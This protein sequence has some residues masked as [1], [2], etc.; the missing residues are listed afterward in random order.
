MKKTSFL[1]GIILCLFTGTAHAAGTCTGTFFNPVTDVCWTCIFPIKI[2]GVT[3]ASFGQEDTDTIDVTPICFCPDRPFPLNLVPGIP[4]SFWEPFRV[5]EVVREPGCFPT[6]GGLKLFST[7]TGSGTVGTTSPAS[8]KH[9]FYHVHYMIY[10]VFYVMELLIDFTCVESSGFDVAYVSEFDPLWMNSELSNFLNP[11]AVLFANV[12][13]QTA[14]IADCTTATAGFPLDPLFWCAGCWGSM[15]P[16]TGHDASSISP[17]QA[18][19]LLATR[20]LAKMHREGLAWG[21]VG[22]PGLC[23]QYPMPV[24]Q[25][26]MYK[27]SMIYPRSQTNGSCCQPIG[28]S[29]MIWGINRTY[30]YAGED[31]GYL[32][33][34]K[35]DCCAF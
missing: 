4:V 3:V 2:G 6:L 1:I 26:S 15:Y 19:S 20:F 17:I 24:I 18:S 31:F 12:A 34:K 27:M 21:S 14:C 7:P 9:S 11:E 33:W 28:R 10:P 16:F 32:L 25:K 23:G 22:T 29:Q 35:R 13:S 30:P 5:I 8:T